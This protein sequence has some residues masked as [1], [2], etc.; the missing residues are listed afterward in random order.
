P[1]LR[2]S[3]PTHDFGRG[4]SK[5]CSTFAAQCTPAKIVEE[6]RMGGNPALLST[7][8]L[9]ATIT[10]GM[11]TLCTA[12]V[13]SIAFWRPQRGAAKTFGLLLERAKVFQMLAVFLIIVAA[14]ALRLADSISSEGVISLLSGVAGYVLGGTACRKEKREHAETEES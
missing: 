1:A 9:Y 2:G 12:I 7:L 8:A 6:V 11:I 4:E 3:S 5:N 14:C 13:G 10:V